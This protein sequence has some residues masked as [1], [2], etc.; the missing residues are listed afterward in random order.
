MYTRTC[1]QCKLVV[2]HTNKYNRDE[3]I[4]KK[5]LCRRCCYDN[6]D[7][8]GDKNPFWGK[9]HTQETKNKIASRDISF[10][11]NPEY[12]LK[13]SLA[14]MG[15]AN[16]M[17]GKCNFEIWTSKYGL[18]E[19]KLRQYKVNKR[20]S[21]V[22]SG[23]M[24]PMYGK[25]SPQGSGNGWSGWYHGWYFRSLRELSYVI[26]HIERNRLDW[27]P[28]ESLRIDYTDWEGHRRTYRADFLVS[29]RFLIEVKP[30]ALHLSRS[31]RIKAEAAERFCRQNGFQ[32]KIEDP[33]L[34]SDN[35][36]VVL[37]HTK[38]VRFLDKYELKFEE[39]LCQRSC[40]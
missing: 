37:H 39:R 32:Y 1:P 27:Q 19:A 2:E 29:N 5:R 34:L 35:E 33:E 28:A 18:T 31:V 23:N 9:T 11:Q 16:P 40:L 14:V 21:E 30:A 6:R 36:I 38:Q 3:A 24:N 17:Y 8:A 7:L 26:N 12:K 4:E 22:F 25:P 20:L 15:E 13:R 10:N